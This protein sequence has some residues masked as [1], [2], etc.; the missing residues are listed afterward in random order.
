MSAPH[1]N[2]E[3]LLYQTL[4]G[5]LPFEEAERDG[6]TQ[7][8]KD[9]FIKAVREAKTFTNWVDPNQPYEEACGRFVDRVLDRSAGNEFWG[10]FEAFQ[11]DISEYGAYNSLSQTTL[12]M[13][14][15]GL[16][17]FYQGTDLWDFSL[18]DPDNRRPVDF[19]KRA[20]LLDELEQMPAEAQS[21]LLQE[22][23]HSKQDGRIKLLLI[24]KGLQARRE[25]KEL[26]DT[27]GYLPASVHGSRTEHVVA[28]FRRR[29]DAHA[30]I[31]VPRFLTSLVGPDQSPLGKD[32]WQDTKIDLPN[33]APPNWRDAITGKT[34][35]A[36]GRGLRG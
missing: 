31:V 18:V 20:K 11:R 7:R 14:C 10:D 36:S 19:R 6:F 12:K 8:I 5:A 28:F 4:V 32:V 21:R 13:T 26:F 25:N 24:H 2:D 22:L 29:K 27:G 34:L 35:T 16:P 17:D 15:P 23:V 3:Y 9:Y 1:P 33:D 30:L